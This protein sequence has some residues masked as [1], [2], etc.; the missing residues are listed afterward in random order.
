MNEID[1]S[2]NQIVEDDVKV[3]VWDD[4]IE[5]ASEMY[6]QS[7]DNRLLYPFACWIGGENKD[8][9]IGIT[10]FKNCSL[11]D[12]RIKKLPKP[13]WD[14]VEDIDW[15][16]WEA[17]WGC[18]DWFVSTK[19]DIPTD[20]L[21]YD[22]DESAEIRQI[23]LPEN[24][25]ALKDC[26]RI[27]WPVIRC[28]KDLA[29]LNADVWSITCFNGDFHEPKVWAYS[30]GIASKDFT[31]KHLPTVQTKQVEAGLPYELPK[32]KDVSGINTTA[33]FSDGN[34]SMVTGGSEL[35]LSIS[36]PK[37]TID[38]SPKKRQLELW[39]IP[40]Y[41][42]EHPDLVLVYFDDDDDFIFVGEHFGT[43]D[44]VELYRTIPADKLASLGRMPTIE[45]CDRLEVAE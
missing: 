25:F 24:R 36:E 42:R 5:S 19:V 4:Y 26:I 28:K 17:T 12:P 21:K 2:K 27:Q 38:W 29:E 33:I 22:G 44:N 45:D 39:E 34:L 10:K 8:R 32:G 11:T 30:D 18:K 20:L 37:S 3:W 15:S 9:S 7:I 14:S 6:L 40:K 31:I 16:V 43:L 35:S 13:I 41:M 23:N 1:L